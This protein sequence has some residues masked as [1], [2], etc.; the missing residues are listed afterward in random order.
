MQLSPVGVSSQR[1]GWLSIGI[2]GFLFLLEKV[3]QIL[4]TAIRIPDRILV[5]S[6]PVTLMCKQTKSSIFKKE[7]K[8][9]KK[10]KMKL[11]AVQ[12]FLVLF[13]QKDKFK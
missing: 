4:V 1:T 9:K 10:G 8:K 11:A 3:E 2:C 12:L 5:V 13:M 6:F 7:V